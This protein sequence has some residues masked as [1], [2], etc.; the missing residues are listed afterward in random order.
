VRKFVIGSL[1]LVLVT[2]AIAFIS[3]MSGSP[4]AT[5]TLTTTPAIGVNTTPPTPMTPA[6]TQQTIPDTLVEITPTQATMKLELLT[7]QTMGF[8]EVSAHGTGN[9]ETIKLSLTSKSGSPIEVSV[10]PGTIFD[11]QPAGGKSSMVVIEETKVLLPPNQTSEL[12]SISAASINMRQDV[13]GES[14]TL[15]LNTTSVSG[16]LRKLIKL[17]D[18]QSDPS[19][20]LQQFA[21]WTITDDPERD[22]Y[23]GIGYFGS[24]SGPSDEEIENIRVLFQKAGVQPEEYQALKAAVYVELIDAQNRGLIEVSACGVGSLESIKLYLT[25]K[26]DTTLEIAILIGTIFDAQST[27]IQGMVVIAQKT[28]ILYPYETSKSISVDAACA[29]MRLSMPGE[30]DALTL[31]IALASGDL[32]KLLNLPDFQ[33]ETYRVQQFAIWTITDNPERD[34]YIG[35][36]YFGSGSGPSDAEI[37]NIRVLFVKAGIQTDQY[38]VFQQ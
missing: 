8:I 38:R 22:D 16:D 6:Q 28:V 2:V 33:K 14:D 17:S 24:G 3:T 29:N 7:A 25:S 23:I 21:I 13:P 1:S 18:F 35:I 15:T 19:F 4:D 9:L 20:R 26:S 30:S 34:D 10:L 31:R 36:G 11:P 5:T 37:E 27:S 32:I 12:V